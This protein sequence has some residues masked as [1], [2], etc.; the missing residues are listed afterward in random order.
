MT[1]KR[2]LPDGLRGAWLARWVA[3][4]GASLPEL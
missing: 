1:E 3:V 4:Q 2:S